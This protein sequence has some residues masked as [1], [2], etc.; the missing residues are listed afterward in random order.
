VVKQARETTAQKSSH[1]NIRFWTRRAIRAT[2]TEAEMRKKAR[3]QSGVYKSQPEQGTMENRTRT[4]E[5]RQ[6][7]SHCG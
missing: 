1:Q 3:V 2:V 4:L 6:G 5:I 7:G